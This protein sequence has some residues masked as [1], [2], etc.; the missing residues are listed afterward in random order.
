M[1]KTYNDICTPR[2]LDLPNTGASSQCLEAVTVLLV[3]AKNTFRFANLA[4]MKSKAAWDQAIESRDLIPLFELYELTP[5]NTEETFYESRNFRKRTGKA[6][7]IT[8]MELY[9]SICSHR[10]LRKLNESSVYNTV[11]EITED[12]DIIGIWDDD[13]VR[14]KGQKLKNFTVGIR[15][16]ATEDKPPFT[17]LSITYNDYD[18]LE[19]NGVIATPLFDPVDDLNGVFN[20]KINTVGLTT[21]TKIDF[22]ATIGCADDTIRDSA[23]SFFKLLDD[24]GADQGAT[25]TFDAQTKLFTAT[26]TGFTDGVITTDGVQKDATTDELFEGKGKVTIG[27]TMANKSGKTVIKT[28]TSK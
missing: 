11:F 14:I 8:T 19:N 15:S 23:V 25:I 26:G 5:A 16:A 7:K 27:S 9:L 18:E 20:V 21:A 1:N 6:S 22:T 3:L 12:G 4:E 28:V 2:E 10:E 13:G 17:P 24:T